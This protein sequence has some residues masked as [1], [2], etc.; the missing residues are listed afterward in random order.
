MDN[1]S[2]YQAIL[3]TMQN[4]WNIFNAAVDQSYLDNDCIAPCV[5][6][7]TISKWKDAIKRSH[8]LLTEAKKNIDYSF[9]KELF[10]IYKIFW[11]CHDE[12]NRLDLILEL[13]HRRIVQLYAH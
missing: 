4:A 11:E 7:L 6:E 2:E 5:T 8:A 9:A 10:N 12:Y 3:V 13:D 1:N